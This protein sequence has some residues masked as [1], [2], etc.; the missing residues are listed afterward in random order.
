[1][2]VSELRLTGITANNEVAGWF[3]FKPFQPSKYYSIVLISLET[4]HS[5]N[6][7]K[8]LFFK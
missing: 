2:A 8:Y 7:C 3:S 6:E 4:S 1:M 5:R